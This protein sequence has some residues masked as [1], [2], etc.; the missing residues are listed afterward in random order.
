MNA[1]ES[2][3]SLYI[4]GGKITSGQGGPPNPS[5]G[6]DTIHLLEAAFFAGMILVIAVFVYIGWRV[7]LDPG[8][9]A[10]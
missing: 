1:P 6:L 7:R 4:I 8:G 3:L 10:K 5:G 9:D 2:Y